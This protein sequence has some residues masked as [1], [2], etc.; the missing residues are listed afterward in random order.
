MQ[1]RWAATQN[2]VRV[3]PQTKSPW[4]Q[5]GRGT[6]PFLRKADSGEICQG[7]RGTQNVLSSHL[8]GV[9]RHETFSTAC[10]FL[11]FA[12]DVLSLRLHTRVV[13]TCAVAML[14]APLLF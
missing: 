10:V 2:L 11:C 8:L 6:V 13:I 3:E 4:L 14:I 1:Y 12:L 9:M 5:C 7:S